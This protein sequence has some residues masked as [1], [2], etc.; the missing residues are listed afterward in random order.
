MQ[1]LEQAREGMDE[2]QAA[3][4]RACDSNRLMAP[5]ASRKFRAELAKVCLT[6]AE[7]L[8]RHAGMEHCS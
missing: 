7:Q 8:A 4:T 2:L 1:A 5:V 6:C 3:Y